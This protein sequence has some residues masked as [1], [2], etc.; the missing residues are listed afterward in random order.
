M[1][2]HDDYHAGWHH[3]GPLR[4]V[5]LIVGGLV[6]AVVCGLAFG[7]LV[8][9]LWNWLM[10]VLFKF[11]IISYWQGFGLV[12]LGRLLFGGFRHPGPRHGRSCGPRFPHAFHHHHWKAWDHRGDGD[13]E[14]WNPGGSYRNWKYYRE[15]WREEGKTAFLAYLE[16]TGK[17]EK[18][19]K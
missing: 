11:P 8:M 16:K 3:R 17:L 7:W 9:L 13:D 4:I 14:E 19:E 12:V 1:E 5:A 6:L 18:P 2:K 15:Y 10:P